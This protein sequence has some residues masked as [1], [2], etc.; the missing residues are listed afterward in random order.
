MVF[1]DD[2]KQAQQKHDTRILEVN[3]NWA[4]AFKADGFE[5]RFP[6][7]TSIFWSGFL[8]EKGREKLT[9]GVFENIS[10][11]EKQNRF[12]HHQISEKS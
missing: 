11:E 10:S 6:T 1:G 5:K 7:D 12:P 8:Y 3:T 2:G 4:Q 9:V